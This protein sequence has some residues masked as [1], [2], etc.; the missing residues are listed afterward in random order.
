MYLEN[1]QLGSSLSESDE[2][3][4]EYNEFEQKAKVR[5]SALCLLSEH[6]NNAERGMTYILR[7]RGSHGKVSASH[8]FKSQLNRFV[9]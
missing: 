1:D 4:Q 2:L 8:S 6:L 7:K 5:L 3:L 9:N